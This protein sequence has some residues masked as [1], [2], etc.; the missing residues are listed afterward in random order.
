MPQAVLHGQPMNNTSGSAARL[1]HE[2][3]P[4]WQ[5]HDILAL[6]EDSPPAGR[7]EVHMALIA[8][9]QSYAPQ[10]S[11]FAADMAAII[12]FHGI[13]GSARQQTWRRT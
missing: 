5:L 3:G 7:N 8:N 2:Q 9:L 10:E 6:L 13:G 1:A 11:P 12:A 4:T